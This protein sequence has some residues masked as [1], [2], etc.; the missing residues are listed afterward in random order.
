[1]KFKVIM[2]ADRIPLGSIVSKINGNRLYSLEQKVD[3]YGDAGLVKTVELDGTYILFPQDGG[4]SLSVIKNDKELVWHVS[5]DVLFRYIES[6]ED[7]Y[8]E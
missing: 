1:M 5:E 6:L 3:F 8:K 4:Y 7:I 2:R